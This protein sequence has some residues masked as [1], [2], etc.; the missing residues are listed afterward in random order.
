MKP[1][2]TVQRLS[3]SDLRHSTTLLKTFGGIFDGQDAAA[4][5]TFYLG[6][7]A[8]LKSIIQ[9]AAANLLSKYASAKIDEVKKSLEGK[10]RTATP[11][12][13]YAMDDYIRRQTGAYE[14][15]LDNSNTYER[16]LLQVL[17]ENQGQQ[18][19]STYIRTHFVTR[20]KDVIVAYDTKVPGSKDTLLTK[21]N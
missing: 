8:N 15:L 12:R 20:I 18:D 21:L 11:A 2:F 19:T 16:E 3:P 6:A 14:N 7:P 10:L 4:V 13:R 9:L 17:H 5:Y 1:N